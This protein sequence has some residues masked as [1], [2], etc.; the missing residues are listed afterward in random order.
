MNWYKKAQEMGDLETT[1]IFK[2]MWQNE[3]LIMPVSIR[4]YR[5]KKVYTIEG[6]ISH[7][8]IY[9]GGLGQVEIS[10]IS[11]GDLERRI[12]TYKDRPIMFG[13]YQLVNAKEIAKEIRESI[14]EMTAEY[15]TQQQ[16]EEEL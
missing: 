3:T 2:N 7:A 11:L 4:H 16:F 15:I 12:A 14:N 8:M 1:A 10:P 5:N 9:F 6:K 13:N